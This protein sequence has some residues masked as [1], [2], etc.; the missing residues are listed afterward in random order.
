MTSPWPIFLRESFQDAQEH[1]ANTES[2]FNTNKTA[3]YAPYN[4]LLCHLF[5]TEGPYQIAPQ[6]CVPTELGRLIDFT[7]L[8]KVQVKK[9]PVS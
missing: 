3:Y 7:I 4:M 5:G 8:L 2:P 6:Y 9:R 1:P